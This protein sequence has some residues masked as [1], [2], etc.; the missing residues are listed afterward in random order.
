MSFT[1]YFVFLSSE[2][3]LSTFSELQFIFHFEF[4]LSLP[5]FNQ[6]CVLLVGNKSDLSDT[7]RITYDTACSFSEIH[8]KLLLT[9]TQTNTHTPHNTHEMLLQ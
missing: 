4:C 1:F 7:R 8:G 6:A 5:Y 3:R 9:D 2:R